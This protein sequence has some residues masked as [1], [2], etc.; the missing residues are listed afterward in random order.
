MKFL[1]Q[2]S[3]L[4]GRA[5]IGSAVSAAA[6][7]IA[8]AGPAA[9]QVFEE[10]TVTAQKR[11]QS[12]QDIPLAVSAFGGEAL[13]A[14]GVSSAT[15]LQYSAPSLSVSSN[16]GVAAVYIRGIGSDAVNS[17]GDPSVAM[18]VNG[19]YIARLESL[20]NPFFDIDRIEVLRGPQGTLYGRNAAGGNINIISRRPDFDASGYMTARLGNYDR[21]KFEG[22]YGGALSN[23]VAARLAVMYDSRDGF[24]DNMGANGPSSLN[25][26]DTVAVRGSVLFSASDDLEFLLVADYQGNEDN[27]TPIKPLDNLGIAEAQ[28]ATIPPGLFQT[29][30]N[31]SAPFNDLETYGVSLTTTKTFEDVTV[32][33][34]TAYRE[35]SLDFLFDSDG[36][37]LRIVDLLRDQ[38][39][40]Q[41]TAELQVS[42]SGESY[43]WLVGAFYF[44]EDVTDD[45][46]LMRS[47][48][49][50]NVP[51][52][53]ANTTDAWAVFGQGSYHFTDRLALTLGIRYSE[54]KK[55]SNG[56][57]FLEP[58]L[59][60]GDTTR[61]DGFVGEDLIP[62]G[63]SVGTE[64]WTDVSPKAALEFDVND[65]VLAYVSVTKGFKSGGFN[66]VGAQPSFDPEKIIAY[67]GGIKGFTTDKSLYF[68]LSGFYYDYDDLQVQIFATG[69]AVTTN[70]AKATIKGAELE[71]N[72]Q[73]VENARMGLI[74]AYLDATYK[75]YLTEDPQT[76]L[77][78]D[79]SGNQ[80]R[81]AP[82]LSASVFGEY[83]VMME[84][85]GELT[86]H[87]EVN[88]KDEVF[89][90]Q[91]N[92]AGVRQGAFALV[93]ARISYVQDRYQIALWGRNLTDKEY[94]NNAV[95]FDTTGFNAQGYLGNPREVGFELGV[96]F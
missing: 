3:R 72:Y 90:D 88:Y 96:K 76:T 93:N 15:D 68:A 23:N 64:K 55:D 38:N 42:G 87:A 16:N 10:I 18:H 48:I 27:G 77:P 80:L 2:K 74:A 41:L 25:D 58:I 20:T 40:D 7:M 49:G 5:M 24:T 29:T 6:L 11:E 94:L 53:G 37:D 44:T 86:F 52:R 66:L 47:N 13:R 56:A 39:Q 19:V 1:Q 85:G 4:G 78:L 46:E 33:L 70:A 61:W 59:D 69:T 45:F 89:F 67:E 32:K 60:L 79:L 57:L 28:G 82:E 17:A 35:H 12:I 31:F 95:R 91:F 83:T 51:I 62:L 63:G 73:P 84:T 65:D 81:N 34:I 8:F 14:S 43:D 36:T 71:L 30:T 92:T 22:A 50:F 75:D 54:E 9:G 21:F 26:L